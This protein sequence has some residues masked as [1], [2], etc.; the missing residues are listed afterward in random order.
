MKMKVLMIALAII[1][2]FTMSANAQLR[3]IKLNNVQGFT[4]TLSITDFIVSNDVI[5]A[6][7][8]LAGTYSNTQ[9]SQTAPLTVSLSDASCDQIT[10]TFGGIINVGTQSIPISSFSRTISS[11]GKNNQVRNSFC[12]IAKQLNTNAS[13][14]AYVAH[15]KNL[16]RAL[17]R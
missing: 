8:T 10:I 7:G 16:V 9:V 11:T 3:N 6:T 1:S 14:N 2:V 12:S 5:T 15:L 4:G 17:S 13:P